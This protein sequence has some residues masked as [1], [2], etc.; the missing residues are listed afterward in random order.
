MN[1]ET[2]KKDTKNE[3]TAEEREYYLGNEM[4]YIPTRIYKSL[5]TEDLTKLINLMYKKGELHPHKDTTAYY[6]GRLLKYV[7]KSQIKEL[8]EKTQ[9]LIN[10]KNGKKI[11]IDPNE[12]T[13]GDDFGGSIGVGAFLLYFLVAMI[14]GYG[15]FPALIVAPFPG[16]AAFHLSLL[17]AELMAGNSHNIDFKDW[18]LT[19][20]LTFASSVAFFLVLSSPASYKNEQCDNITYQDFDRNGNVILKKGR[21][22]GEMRSQVHD[23]WKTD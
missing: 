21:V 11:V 9:R 16:M 3:I 13:W 19:I 7:R 14:Q 4:T 22:C 17:I 6:Y 15:F 18:I 12:T 8:S 20:V 2:E 5:T 10:H 1:D 23:R